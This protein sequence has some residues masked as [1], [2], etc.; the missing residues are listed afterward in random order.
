MSE[1]NQTGMFDTT[2]DRKAMRNAVAHGTVCKKS[3]TLSNMLMP[4]PRRINPFAGEAE[5]A[6]ERFAAAYRIKLPHFKTRSS[7]CAY[8]FP[9]ATLEKLVTTGKIFALSWFID[10]IADAF[11]LEQRASLANVDYR[12]AE[13]N[14]PR[15]VE[16]APILQ[17][18]VIFSPAPTMLERATKEIADDLASAPLYWRERFARLV[19]EYLALTVVSK[20]QQISSVVSYIPFRLRDSGML[21]T[22][23]MAEFASGCFLPDRVYNNPVV[24]SM[25]E[26]VS[27]VGSL[28]NDLFSYDRERREQT[29]FNLLEIL[30]SESPFEEAVDRS[31]R[32][33]NQ[34]VQSFMDAKALIPNDAVG[35]SVALEAFIAASW[36]WQIDTPRY[37]S[38][39]SSF[40]ELR[41]SPS[42]Y[43]G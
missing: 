30:L 24:W 13:N 20:D 16:L 38:I 36:Y 35:F 12:I 3:L 39:D 26:A 29:R 14:L 2:Y 17:T 19:G 4:Y 31:I 32:I 34:S 1:L 41:V 43:L 9:N 7:M 23:A 42:P 8:L 28:S 25:I 6:V 21:F 18:G 40:A 22:C 5:A 10:E 11:T 15:L 33:I 37:R 27:K